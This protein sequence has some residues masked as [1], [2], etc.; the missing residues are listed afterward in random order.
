MPD[1]FTHQTGVPGNSLTGLYWCVQNGSYKIECDIVFT[2]DKKAVVLHPAR[3]DVINHHLGRPNTFTP[4][5][6]LQQVLDLPRTDYPEEK[7]LT[8]QDLWNFLSIRPKVKILF[9]VKYYFF[10]ELEGHFKTIGNEMID[11]AIKELVEPA[12]RAGVADQIGFSAFLGG[13][14]LLKTAKIYCPSITTSFIIIFPWTRVEDYFPYLDE[15]IIG[16]TGL[17]AWVWKLSAGRIKHLIQEA[18][19]RNIQ[20][21]GGCANNETEVRRFL[22]YGVDGIW[23]DNPPLVKKILKNLTPPL[24]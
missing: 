3:Q 23:T 13:A 4:N 24:I 1:I 10:H 16:Q 2:K 12:R 19:K 8:P 5:L 11:L 22:K 20:V 14:K 15:I 21:N 7:I 9:D 18:K 17:N 6:T